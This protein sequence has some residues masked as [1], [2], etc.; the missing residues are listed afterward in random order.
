MKESKACQQCGGPEETRNSCTIAPGKWLCR[1]CFEEL[2]SQEFLDL[3]RRAMDESRGIVRAG[4][5]C[6]HCGES[7]P[8]GGA[9]PDCGQNI[10][11]RSL[12]VRLLAL[13]TGFNRHWACP[14]AN[15]LMPASR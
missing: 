6:A 13:E 11:T 3:S 7:T 15:P 1:N 2:S 14:V 5:K 4:Q 9:C 8:L 10:C 12:R